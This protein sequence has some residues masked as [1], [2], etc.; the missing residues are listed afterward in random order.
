M[1]GVQT[2]ALPIY[3]HFG[4]ITIRARVTD[5]RDE[6]HQWWLDCSRGKNI[7]KSITV[8]ALNQHGEPAREWNFHSAFP[9]RWD[10]GEYS[11]SSNAA[12]PP[13]TGN[14]VTIE[15]VYEDLDMWVLADSDGRK[16]DPGNVHLVVVDD[17]GGKAADTGWES[18][19]GGGVV[20]I[21]ESH[22][23]DAQFHTTT[24]GHK[25]IDTLTL[26]GPL[27]PGR[28]AL[29][30]W[31]TDTVKGQPWKRTVTVKEILKDGSDGKTFTYLDC[32]PTRYVFPQFD[33]TST[34]NLYEEV[35]IKPIRLELS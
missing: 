6:L 34:G 11:P 4:S 18:W 26:R 3:A 22:L 19:S 12:V 28:K 31:I 16:E 20:H 24:P 32:F 30:Q 15:C 29:C 2:C 17:A 21:D 23:A 9:V 10:P 7:R 5:R 8:I 1:T 33:A 14:V 35:H 13:T 27:T 25:Y